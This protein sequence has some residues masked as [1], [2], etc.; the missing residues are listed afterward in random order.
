MFV[1]PLVVRETSKLLHLSRFHSHSTIHPSIHLSVQLFIHL[2]IHSSIQPFIH[3]S[4]QPFIHPSTQPLIHPSIHPSIR[5]ALHPSIHSS[6]HP[7]FH[8]SIHS[9]LHNSIHPS[10]HSSIHHLIYPSIQCFIHPSIRPSIHPLIY[11]SPFSPGDLSRAIQDLR[12]TTK[13]VADNTEGFLKLSTLLYDVGD[14]E[15]SLKSVGSG[16][17]AV[18]LGFFLVEFYVFYDNF[19]LLS[20]F[21]YFGDFS[22][23]GWYKGFMGVWGFSQPPKTT[24][25]TNLHTSFFSPNPFSLHKYLPPST[26]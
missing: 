9:A 10:I 11:L 26:P 2:F 22:G 21:Q 14:A 3:P 18:F 13:L 17:S 12:P 1:G 23:V 24:H 4:I 20:F 16:D 19:S 7:A 15:E 8:S 25:Y 5:P 6:I